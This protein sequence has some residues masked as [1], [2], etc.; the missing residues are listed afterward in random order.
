M[1]LGIPVSPFQS[2][3]FD[4]VPFFPPSVLKY[5]RPQKCT[6]LIPRFLRMLLILLLGGYRINPR[7]TLW[8][9]EM[10]TVRKETL[11]CSLSSCPPTKAAAALPLRGLSKFLHLPH[12]PQ[13]PA[14]SDLLFNTFWPMFTNPFVY[15]RKWDISSLPSFLFLF[16]ANRVW[17][18]L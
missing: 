15:T 7:R 9:Q 3:H 13:V 11:F 14:C 8:G 1:A 6:F 12:L 16:L 5:C 4:L 17:F 2:P 10:G 18:F